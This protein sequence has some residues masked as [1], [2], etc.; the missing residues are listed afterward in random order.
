VLFSFFVLFVVKPWYVATSGKVFKHEKHEKK[1]KTQ[2]F[3]AIAAVGGSWHRQTGDA[4][5]KREFK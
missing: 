1:R 3:M 4:C 2:K 5:E